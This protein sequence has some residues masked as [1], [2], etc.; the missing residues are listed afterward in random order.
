MKLAS[1]RLASDSFRGEALMPEFFQSILGAHWEFWISNAVG[2]LGVFFP[3]SEC[4]T[5]GTLSL[6]SLRGGTVK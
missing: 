5:N 4:G 2:A 6:S 3:Q 1:V